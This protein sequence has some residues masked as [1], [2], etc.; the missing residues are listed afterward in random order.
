MGENILETRQVEEIEE[1]EVKEPEEPTEE[2]SEE[3]V[4]EPAK[5]SEV[6]KVKPVAF[7]YQLPAYTFY[8]IVKTINSVIGYGLETGKDNA[9]LNLHVKKDGIELRSMDKSRVA[10][11]S[12]RLAKQGFNTYKVKNAGA[13]CFDA[14]QLLKVLGG[15]KKESLNED[16]TVKT[17]GEVL[18][19]SLDNVDL[20]LNLQHSEYTRTFSLKALEPE[21]GE[22]PP[23]PKIETTASFKTAAN[24]LRRILGDAAKASDHITISVDDDG[25]QFE[26]NGEAGAVSYTGKLTKL[27]AE[28]TMKQPTKATYN[29]G[30]LANMLKNVPKDTAMIDF[31]FAADMPAHLQTGQYDKLA[32]FLAPRIEVD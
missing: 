1:P 30:F 18:N 29:L 6:Q 27:Q 2:K 19:L 10:M 17:E 8:E 9:D 31:E 22:M 16:G 24:L 23:E 28:I 7:T 15:V 13:V 14:V 20:L 32:F 3:V 25:V 12:F 26:A 5:V 21:D 4:E 11:V